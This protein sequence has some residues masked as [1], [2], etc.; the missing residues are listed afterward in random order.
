LL[1]EM[2]RNAHE[3][4]A[5]LRIS[6]GWTW[7]E[8]RDDELRTHPNLVDYDQLP[9]NEKAYDRRVVAETTKVLLLRGMLRKRPPRF[10][11]QRWRSYAGHGGR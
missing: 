10:S 4:W 9:E 2:A 1:E 5:A 6:E 7:G 8:S 3:N 11:A